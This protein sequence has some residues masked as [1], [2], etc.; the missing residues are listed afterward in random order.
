MSYQAPTHRLQVLQRLE[1]E[2]ALPADDPRY[3]ET[4]QARGSE[5]TLTRLASKFGWDPTKNEFFAPN[6]KH[7][8]FFGHIGSG[9]TTELRHYMERFDE[10]QRF[11]VVE[12]DVLTKLD[13]NN[14]QYTE[15]LM[16]MAE[17]LLEHL[18]GDGYRFDDAALRP[19]QQWFASAVRT[20]ALSTSL[21]ADVR[22]GVE[23]GV[24]IPG[25]IKL[26]ANFTSSFKTGASTKNEW[27]EEIRN[28]FT[29]LV[30]AFNGLIRSAEAALKTRGRAER[31]LFLV[32][33]TDK[34]RG[35]DTQK[36]FV[37][38]AEQLLAIHTLAIYTAPLNLKYDGSLGGKLDADM[39]L[40]MIKLQDRDDARWEPGWT[41]LRDLLL[42]RADRSLFAAGAEGDAQ[43]D[44]LVQ[45]CGGHPRELLRLLKL[46]C[47]M[48]DDKLDAPVVDRAIAQLASEYRRFLLPDDYKLLAAIDADPV[49]GGNDTRAQ[50]LL[51]RLALL[52][53]N[54]GGWRRSHPVIRTLDGYLQAMTN[55]AP[56]PA[57][58]ATPKA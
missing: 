52:E 5:Q 33:G 12:V 13:R 49:H 6:E 26:L 53:Y 58:A 4:E 19:M 38:D 50:E 31:V 16:A 54:D 34:M 9:K 45:A 27:R 51:Y 10:S 36:F 18:N 37:L 22:T 39:V 23:A 15:V 11:Y 24:G 30:I 3:V 56:K 1:Y 14:L 32:D 57:A 29:S 2:E 47:E 17:S 20:R 40:P 48:A 41:V 55:P 28:R 42:R 7:V 8:L 44:R 21:D 35:E 46:C 43:I 25:L